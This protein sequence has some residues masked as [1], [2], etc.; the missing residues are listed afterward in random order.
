CT[1]AWETPCNDHTCS[2]TYTW[3]DV[4]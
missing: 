1:R 3:L 2:S 4:W